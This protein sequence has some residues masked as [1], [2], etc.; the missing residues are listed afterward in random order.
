MRAFGGE[1]RAAAAHALRF[2]PFT[3]VKTTICARSPSVTTS[4]LRSRMHSK[5]SSWNV[6]LD[7]VEFTEPGGAHSTVEQLLAMAATPFTTQSQELSFSWCPRSYFWSGSTLTLVSTTCGAQKPFCAVSRALASELTR[8]ASKEP[9]GIIGGEGGGHMI[10]RSVAD[11]D[12]F[13]Q[14]S[15]RG[16]DS[17]QRKRRDAP[18]KERPQSSR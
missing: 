2:D 14:C 11:V 16:S 1:Q 10:V 8:T 6:R 12:G 13:K 9:I 5:D 7:E 4:E 3:K 15:K 17:L 18:N